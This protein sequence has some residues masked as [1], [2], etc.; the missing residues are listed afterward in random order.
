MPNSPTARPGD[1]SLSCWLTLGCIG[2]EIWWDMDPWSWNHR[3]LNGLVKGT[4]HMELVVST[5]PKRMVFHQLYIS[6]KWI[7][8]P[9]TIDLSP[10]NINK[11]YLVGG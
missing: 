2:P 4:I 6:Y 8:I 1:A 5:Y 9:L 11:P 3:T 10:I 7:I